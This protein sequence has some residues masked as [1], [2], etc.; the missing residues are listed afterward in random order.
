MGCKGG[1]CVQ[2]AHSPYKGFV[3][4]LMRTVARSGVSALYKSYPTT[5]RALLPGL[6]EH[7]MP[8]EG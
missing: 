5:V 1:C 3:D 4:C 8:L 6:P 7:A 2:V